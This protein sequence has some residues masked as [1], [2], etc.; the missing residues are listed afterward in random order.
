MNSQYHRV[1][2]ALSYVMNRYTNFP[3]VSRM[4]V[5]DAINDYLIEQDTRIKHLESKINN[6]E[7]NQEQIRKNRIKTISDN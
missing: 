3:L 1:L 7:K 4:H 5:Y 6:L 2:Q